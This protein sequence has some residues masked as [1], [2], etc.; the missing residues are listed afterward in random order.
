M[1]ISAKSSKCNNRHYKTLY[2]DKETTI[3][4]RCVVQ[5]EFSAILC[6]KHNSPRFCKKA[7][8]MSM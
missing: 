7:E 6:Q 5:F 1:S 2:V 3:E 8:V 4:K